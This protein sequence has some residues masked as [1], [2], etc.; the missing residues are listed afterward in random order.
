LTEVNTANQHYSYPQLYNS[1]IMRA[2]NTSPRSQQPTTRRN[3]HW[4]PI[5]PR[6]P[7]IGQSYVILSSSGT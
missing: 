4:L 7:L 2:F 5:W 3:F 1:H 6:V